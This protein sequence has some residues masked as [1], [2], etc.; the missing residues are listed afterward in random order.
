MVF[1]FSVKAVLLRTLTLP[2]GVH[3]SPLVRCQLPR[4]TLAELIPFTS[5]I[6]LL[7]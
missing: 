7:T 2:Y 1:L 4:F 6:K 5:L 3:L